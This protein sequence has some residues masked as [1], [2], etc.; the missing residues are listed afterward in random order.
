MKN[1]TNIVKL[2]LFLLIISLN[3]ALYF[4]H[5]STRSKNVTREV[6][7]H[8][9]L[10][11]QYWG[12]QFFKNENHF[13]NEEVFSGLT[14]YSPS[15]Y[16]LSLGNKDQKKI[17]FN[18]GI[19]NAAD[20]RGD[21]VIFKVLLVKKGETTSKVVFQETVL[22][23]KKE[24][25]S[26]RTGIIDLREY[27]KIPIQLIFLVDKREN[28]A[29]DQSFWSNI[30]YSYSSPTTFYI[31]RTLSAFLLLIIVYFEKFIYFAKKNQLLL[32]L[33]FLVF[34]AFLYLFFLTKG[35]YTFHEY[36]QGTYYNWL[37]DL[38]DRGMLG[39]T[40]QYSEGGSDKSY[41]Q[42]K[43]YLYFGPFPAII[44]F[45]ILK[46]FS[47]LPNSSTLTYVFSIINLFLFWLLMMMLERKFFSKRYT[48]GALAVFITYASGP[49]LFCTSRS[50][51]Y[52]EGIILGTTFLVASTYCFLNDFFSDKK[53]FS[54]ILLSGFFFTFAFLSRYNLIL[55]AIISLILFVYSF[56]K[57]NKII[58]FKKAL[59]FSIPVLIGLLFIF[60][61]NYLRFN[62][63]K[64]FGFS[65][66]Q[67]SNPEDIKRNKLGQGNS[68]KYLKYNLYHYFITMPNIS[69]RNAK[70]YI[71]TIGHFPKLVGTE[72][73]SSVFLNLPITLFFF[74]FLLG[75]WKKRGKIPDKLFVSSIAILAGLLIM[76]FY[77]STFMG[78]TRRYTQDFIPYMALLSFIGMRIYYNKLRKLK[79]L[80][81]I[82]IIALLYTF[83]I[84]TAVTCQYTTHG[85]MNRCL[86][87]YN[88]EFIK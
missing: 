71:S 54:N 38:F 84:N 86:K 27:Q 64:E 41:Y 44:H 50:W 81:I 61:Y 70:Q 75:I 33:P 36:S 53:G 78:N 88:K 85:N 79:T 43:R 8:I 22:P 35:T 3:T 48:F 82:I 19:S 26:L 73:A 69:K 47:V 37:A 77:L 17:K 59:V 42:G 83:L 13:V 58:V 4:F 60:T 28:N 66:V 21:G 62:D 10:Q 57:K 63:I 46:I 34:F 7:G 51:V 39:E 31:L 87:I 32:L 12:N 45:I 15:L 29:Y 76:V 30:E 16:S 72:Y 20:G 2:V 6:Q 14:A 55:F 25:N 74:L 5:D 80:Q 65:Y 1:S 49:L 23:E 9:E 68:L 52:E 40:T 18:Y 67:T 24:N 56:L 11:N